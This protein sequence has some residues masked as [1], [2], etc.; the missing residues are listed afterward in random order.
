MVRLS[1]GVGAIVNSLHS[2]SQRLGHGVDDEL[3]LVTVL[4]GVGERGAG[5]GVAL[6][7]GGPRR[8]TGE[9]LARHPVAVARDQQLRA[10]ADQGHARVP[11]ARRGQVDQIAVGRRV[12]GDQAAQDDPRRPAAPSATS[13]KARASTTF[14]SGLPGR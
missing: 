13:R 10:G 12:V 4:G 5:G 2:G 3:V 14:C 8:G 9:G 1:V 7:V 6:G 11:A